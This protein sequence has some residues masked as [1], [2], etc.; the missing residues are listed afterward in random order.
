MVSLFRERTASSHCDREVTASSWT[1]SQKQ[2]TGTP[3]VV[4]AQVQSER[5]SRTLRQCYAYLRAT[6]AG[7]V[8]VVF[9][10]LAAGMQHLHVRAGN[11]Q[12]SLFESA[13]SMITRVEKLQEA[14]CHSF[15]QLD[16]GTCVVVTAHTASVTYKGGVRCR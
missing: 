2:H 7:M 12:A 13:L 10:A 9:N 15:L 5:S 11:H 6:A 1:L 16:T 4:A 14:V 8:K 3:L